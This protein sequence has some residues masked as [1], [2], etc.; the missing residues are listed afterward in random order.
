MKTALTTRQRA[1]LEAAIDREI[2]RY[3]HC[4]KLLHRVDATVFNAGIEC[5][6]A[7]PN[8]V[9]WLCAPA[10]TLGRQIPLRAMRTAA[11]REKVIGVLRAIEH[12]VYQ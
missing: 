7:A 4:R 1:H 6:G 8:F 10:R 3:K 11:G 2:S 5:F 12:G 9:Y